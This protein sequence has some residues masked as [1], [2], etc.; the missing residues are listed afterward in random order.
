[1][2]RREAFGSI[3][4]VL[5]SATI[6][7]AETKPELV[8]MGWIVYSKINGQEYSD[9]YPNHRQYTPSKC[10]YYSNI[11]GGFVLPNVL[12]W[13]P[14]MNAKE[15]AHFIAYVNSRTPWLD[16]NGLMTTEKCQCHVFPVY[17]LKNKGC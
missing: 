6:A 2:N 16:A 14:V 11:R 4:A 9:L 13:K 17:C 12:A 5:G 7:A 1:M 8:E 15:M 10:D 3:G